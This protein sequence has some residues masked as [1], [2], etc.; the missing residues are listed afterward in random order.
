MEV[1]KDGDI[2]R[3]T[4]APRQMND[5]ALFIGMINYWKFDAR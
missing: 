3:E 5:W 2:V 1:S 4:V